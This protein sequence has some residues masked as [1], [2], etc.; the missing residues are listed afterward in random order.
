MKEILLAFFK[1][2]GMK[3]ALGSVLL[4]FTV[5]D[6]WTFKIQLKDP[7]QLQSSSAKAHA[8]TAS[9]QSSNAGMVQQTQKEGRTQGFSLNPFSS[10]PKGVAKTT[11]RSNSPA[12]AQLGTADPIEI[13]A[14]IKRFAHVALGEQ[15]KY[16]VP[17]SITIANALLMSTANQ[18]ASAKDLNN[19]FRLPCS[20]GLVSTQDFSEGVCLLKFGTAWESFRTHSKLLQ[21]W[22]LAQTSPLGKTDYKAWATLI[23]NNFDNGQKKYH[24]QLIQLIEDLEL[25]YL[26]VS[27]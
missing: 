23:S 12:L 20:T 24:K 4:F 1:Q 18:Q 7:T 26:D 14:F 11:Q 22:N 19:Y 16:G 27:S 6:T 5:Q 8:Q 3:I 13:D 9:I 25:F 10:K 15:Q 17:A 21:G 2:N